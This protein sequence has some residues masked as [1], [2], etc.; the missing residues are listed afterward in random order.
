MQLNSVRLPS[1]SLCRAHGLHLPTCCESRFRLSPHDGPRNYLLVGCGVTQPAWLSSVLALPCF[2]A[3]SLP[4]SL[5]FSSARGNIMIGELLRCPPRHKLA[6]SGLLCVSWWVACKVHFQRA[7]SSPRLG[8][9]VMQMVRGNISALCVY[10][11][12]SWLMDA[13]TWRGSSYEFRHMCASTASTSLRFVVHPHVCSAD[14][15]YFLC[16]VL[17]VA[18]LWRS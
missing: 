9:C 8:T 12:P 3:A 1:S 10:F 13:S 14:F 5:F 16:I 11:F 7:S 4:N 18:V 15:Q 6:G 17:G 2:I